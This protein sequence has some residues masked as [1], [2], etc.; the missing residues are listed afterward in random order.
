[1]ITIEI[2]SKS[3][4]TGLP[5]KVRFDDALT[6]A[7]CDCIHWQKQI[8]AEQLI[9]HEPDYCDHMRQA[10]ELIASNPELTIPKPITLASFR[11][12]GKKRRAANR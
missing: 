6:Y 8:A 12:T 4:P 7:S 9:G 3:N 1:M 5:H 2:P 11:D 10:A